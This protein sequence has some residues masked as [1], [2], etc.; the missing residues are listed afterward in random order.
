MIMNIDIRIQPWL[1][2]LF[3]T[4]ILDLHTYKSKEN[5]QVN[6]SMYTIFPPLLHFTKL[7]H[8]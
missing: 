3:S 5:T 8:T 6:T 4:S 7:I 2:Y 1:T